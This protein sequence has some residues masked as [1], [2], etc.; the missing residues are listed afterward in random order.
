MKGQSNASVPS[1]GSKVY[2]GTV[3]SS[4]SYAG[5]KI[6][7]PTG[8]SDRN[9]IARVSLYHEKTVGQSLNSGILYLIAYPPA[10]FQMEII[11]P[12]SSTDPC[13]IQTTTDYNTAV[14]ISKDIIDIRIKSA[15]F[16]ATFY[17]EVEEYE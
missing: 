2:R 16:N 11:K 9:K 1:G 7:N 5:I 14:D 13:T 12:S 4:S 10:D 8:T 6:P 15:A 17:W 3:T